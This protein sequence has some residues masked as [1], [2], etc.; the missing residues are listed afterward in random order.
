MTELVTQT[1]YASRRGVKPQTIFVWKKQNRI[2]MVG[3]KVDVVASDKRMRETESPGHKAGASERAGGQLAEE[4]GEAK[5]F[6]VSRAELEAIKVKR[7]QIDL[8]TTTAL[9]ILREDAERQAFEDG[10][11][12]RDAMMG[13]P[14][15][16]A[17]RLAT[18]INVREMREALR[19][20]LRD[21]ISGV[22]DG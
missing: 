3:R 2:V 7:A 8:D 18:I 13:L 9:L 20:M 4:P 10:R 16:Y 17:D 12:F 1:E 19:L 14:D 22:S 21:A 15:Q 5:D 6:Y 11:R